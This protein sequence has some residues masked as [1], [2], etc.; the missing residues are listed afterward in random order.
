MQSIPQKMVVTSTVGAGDTLVAGLC[1]AE[2]NQWDKAQS[3]SF[4]TAL[5]VLTV[6]QIG[7]GVE[8]ISKVQAMQENIQ[9]TTQLIEI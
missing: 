4:V 8:D 7:V 3:L 2:L 6:T 1:W 5:A 9:I